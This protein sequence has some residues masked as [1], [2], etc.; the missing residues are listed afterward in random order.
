MADDEF[1]ENPGWH[2]SCNNP[3]KSALFSDYDSVRLDSGIASI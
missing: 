2:D 1:L 3:E